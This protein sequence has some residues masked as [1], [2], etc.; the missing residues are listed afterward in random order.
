MA[1]QILLI[2]DDVSLRRVTEFNLQ[3]AGYDVLTAADGSEGLA[4]FKRH[5]PTLVI[6]DVQ[7][8][9]ISGYEVLEQILQLEPQTLVII[10]TAFS[11]VEKAVTAMKSGAYDYL[12]KPFSRD[13][14][15][16]TVSKAFAF[17]NLRRENIRLKDAL[18]GQSSNNQIV[19]QSKSM[20]NLL[21]RVAKVAASQASVLISG[22]SGTGKEVIAKA[23]HSGSE[24]ADGTFVAVNCAAIPKDLIE[25]ELFGHIKGSFTGA[26]KDRSGKFSLANGGTLF[27]DEIGELPLDLQPKLLRALQEQEIEPVGGVPEKVD[28]RIV[29]ATN[30]NLEEAMLSG[31]FREDLFYRL[32]VVPMEIP[33]LRERKD[34]IPLLLDFFLKKK[35]AGVKVRFSDEV[36]EHLQKYSWPGNVREL[37][38]VVEQMLI[39]RQGDVLELADLPLRIGRSPARA[40]RVLNLPEDGYSLEALEQE[41]VEIALKRCD[42]NKTKAAAFLRIPRHTLLYRLEKYSIQ[43]S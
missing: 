22:E 32:A 9:G 2:D 17:G 27:L 16:L 11:S 26:V 39:L 38:N 19:G 37:E 13:Q 12:T 34:D 29:A 42:G 20:Q 7:M 23:L 31:E 24:R 8:P 43:P 3:E 15:S 6:T 33:P 35:Q 10:V 36:L 1:K 41:A 40:N 30:R 14:L 18:S 28:V 25:S 21:L 5:R 4:L